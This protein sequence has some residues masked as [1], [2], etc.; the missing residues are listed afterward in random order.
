MYHIGAKKKNQNKTKQKQH[1]PYSIARYT[2]SESGRNPPL[3]RISD[4]S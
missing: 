4:N 2:T 1:D 3:L